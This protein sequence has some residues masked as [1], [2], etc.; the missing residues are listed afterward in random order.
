MII[1]PE[2]ILCAV[3]F[4]DCSRQALDHA[5]GLARCY[6]SAVTADG[7]NTRIATRWH[8]PAAPRAARSSS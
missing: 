6:G 4:S 7:R 5:L 8:A 2:R 3:D 1:E